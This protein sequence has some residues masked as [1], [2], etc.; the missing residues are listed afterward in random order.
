MRVR[1]RWCSAVRLRAGA[2]ITFAIA[3]IAA[4]AVYAGSGGVV[5]GASS[6]PTPPAKVT[7]PPPAAF[8]SILGVLRQPGSAAHD[9][10]PSVLS[11]QTGLYVDSVRFA[12]AAFARA[13]YVWIAS[14][15]AQ[16]HGSGNGCDRSVGVALWGLGGRGGGGTSGATPAQIE[17]HGMWISI[18]GGTGA[19]PARTLFAG[20]V[21]DGVATVTLDYPAGKLGGFSHRSGPALTATGHVVNNVVVISVERA[22][23]Q[24]IRMVTTT[25]RAADGATV[26]TFHG[27]F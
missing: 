1:V 5:A 12:R 6:C 24:A 21:P 23:A 7:G 11:S 15:P 4:I 22:G 26:K 16:P 13:W 20:V 10:P 17:S 8:L 14:P 27:T 18:G 25:W 19:D 2:V 9:L 3:A